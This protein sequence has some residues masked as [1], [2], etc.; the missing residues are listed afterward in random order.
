MCYNTLARANQLMRRTMS[1][2]ATRSTS[3]M[4][5]ELDYAGEVE[6]VHLLR[7]IRDEMGW[8]AVSAQ[9]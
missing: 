5:E 2:S 4:D 3:F 9:Q 7:F 8:D 1:K 6:V